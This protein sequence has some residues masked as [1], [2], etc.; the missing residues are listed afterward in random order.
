MDMSLGQEIRT[1]MHLTR[2]AGVVLIM[3]R[4]SAARNQP[5]PRDTGLVNATE[6]RVG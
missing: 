5:E 1:V 6:A 4:S 3:G 2:G